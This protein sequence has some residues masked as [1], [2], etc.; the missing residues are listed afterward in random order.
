MTFQPV[1]PLTGYVGWRFLERTLEN[2]QNAFS[3]SQPVM[4]ATEYFRD[5]IGDVRTADDLVADRQLL[6]VALGAFGLDEDINNTFYIKKILEEGTID[7]GALANRLSDNRFADFSRAFG[8]GDGVFARTGLTGFAGEITDRYE[9]RQFERAVGEQNNDLRLAMNVSTGID[10]ILD[11][12]SSVNAQ[13]FSIMGNAPLREVFQTAL[14]L[15][16]SIASIDLDK[17]LE[18][19]Q[20]RSA[21]V[22]GTDQVT[23]FADPDQQEKLIRLFL[24]RSEA[25]D[26]T[27]ASGS[28]TALTLLQSVSPLV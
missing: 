7:D 11:R 14:G 12:T 25:A 13:W 16:S 10:D 27:A 8:F 2:Q 24:V 1:V 17:Q 4:R 5:K 15:P 3:E 21:S 23:D 19:F 28:S 20:D 18:L 6:S 22:F 26:I 9:A